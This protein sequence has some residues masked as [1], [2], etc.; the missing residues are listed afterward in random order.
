MK[1][2]IGVLLCLAMLMGLVT[3][4]AGCSGTNREELLKIYLPGEYMDES[5]FE[6]FEAWYEEQTGNKVKVQAKTFEAVE[7]IQREVEVSKED[8]DLLCPSDYMVEYLIKKNLLQEI[9][10]SIINVEED[11]LFKPEYLETARQ[12]DPSLKYSVPYMYGTLGLVY[13]ITKTGGELTSWDSLFGD[14]FAGKRSIKDSMRDAYAAACIYNARADIAALEGDAKKAKIQSIF[15]DTTAATVEAAGNTLRAIKGGSVWD[16]DN[17]KFEMAANQS[18]V[19]VALMW[20]CD[21]GYVMNDY[22]DD[23]GNDKEGNRNLWYVV[24]EEGG[25]VYIDNFV[26]SAY[27]KNAKAANY[28]I[29]YLCTKD[30]AVKNSEYAGCISPVAAVYDELYEGYEEDE[31]GMFEG[32]SAEWKAM[33]METMFPSVET[34]NRCGIMKDF[35]AGQSAV[36]EM[37][38]NIRA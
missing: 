30:I 28:F 24:P 6:T 1:R 12:Y 26:I 18:N 13:D 27:A 37:W 20:S 16:V 38:S 10:K 17:V 2:L 23:Q 3:V 19:A 15:E 29:K 33:F 35:G 22:E 36:V 9:D 32:V 8:Y 14:E 31:D 34:L 25:N 7:D 5:I 11:G 21:A 4:F